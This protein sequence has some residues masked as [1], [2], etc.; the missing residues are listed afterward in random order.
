MLDPLDDDEGGEWKDRE[1]GLDRRGEWQDQLQQT[2]T[3]ARE[4]MSQSDYRR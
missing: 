4:Q 2:E 1:E 3:E